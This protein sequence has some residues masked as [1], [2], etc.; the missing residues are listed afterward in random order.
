LTTPDRQL[1]D[2]T[3]VVAVNGNADQ[4]NSP[5]RVGLSFDARIDV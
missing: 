2:F 1:V 5:E 4:L 3:A